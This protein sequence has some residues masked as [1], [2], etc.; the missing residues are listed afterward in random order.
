[1]RSKAFLAAALLLASCQIPRNQGPFEPATS[2]AAGARTVGVFIF[3]GVFNTELAG[4]IDVFQHAGLIAEQWGVEPPIRVI[5]IGPSLDPIT[6]AEGLRIKPA[7]SF[8]DAPA[9]EIFV[10]P[11]GQ[12]FDLDMQNR[13]WTAWIAAMSQRAQ[14][15]I[16]H[17]WGTFLLG[18]AGRLEG[19]KVTTFPAD[20]EKLQA[21]FAGVKAVKDA[22][23]IHDGTVITSAAGLASYEASLYLVH[24]LYGE[25]LAKSVAG[26]LVFAPENL[27]NSFPKA[28]K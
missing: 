2:E 26:G 20:V 5:T 3:D 18:A 9:V 6:T 4:P 23:F 8:T 21:T 17:G 14:Y 19:K 7:H 24:L 25:K 16:G 10:V 12:R 15:T 27:E 11:S 28:K 22:R 13:E 1:M